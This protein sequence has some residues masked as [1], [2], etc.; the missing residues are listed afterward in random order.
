MSWVFPA[1]WFQ[2]DR[3]VWRK[4]QYNA[5]VLHQP[6]LPLAP[7]TFE[8]RELPAVDFIP[9]RQRAVFRKQKTEDIQK[10]A[11][12]RRRIGVFEE[13]MT[14]PSEPHTGR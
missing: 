10:T 8:P 4:A 12:C 9:A 3:R 13:E 2:T 1:A 7:I 5:V 11:L 6:G 14:V